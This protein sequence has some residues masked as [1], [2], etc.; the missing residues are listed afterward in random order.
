MLI[1]QTQA[2]KGRGRRQRARV[3][4]ATL[5]IATAVSQAANGIP[6]DSDATND[7]R[8]KA[9][10]LIDKVAVAAGTYADLRAKGDVQYNYTYRDNKTATS[11]VSTERYLFDGELSWARYGM[12]EVFVFPGQKGSA[13]Q[14]WDGKVA[15]TTLDGELVG[16]SEAVYLTR[17]LRRTNFYWFAMMQK[18][19]DPGTKHEYK[20]TRDVQGV[21]YELVE[22]GFEVPEGKKSDTFLLYI[23][24][25][26]HRVDRF[27]YT[28]VDFGVTE[29]AMME[30]VEYQ[31]FGDIVLPVT[32]RY[33]PALSW[34]GEVAA[35]AV[36][37]DQEM[38][39]IQFGN[40][41]V[42]ADF[43]PPQ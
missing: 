26:T 41:F 13:V 38:K 29:P 6:R 10:A 35:D 21:T 39:D 23:H 9:K 24:P 32:R 2:P 27:L 16:T 14:S 28:A 8:S 36:W 25:E 3:F 33:A 42:P 19:S 15:W 18:L 30:V 43:G 5:L 31:R 37:V 20:G 1:E 7:S 22:M 11:D 12:H 4:L 17:T 40:G 34:K